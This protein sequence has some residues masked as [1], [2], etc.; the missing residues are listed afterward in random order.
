MIGSGEA[1]L[2]ETINYVLH[3][4]APEEQQI[5]ADNVYLTGGCSKF[6]GLLER[7]D[8]EL[9]EMRPFETTHRIY[10]AKNPALD[11]WYGARDFAA[12]PNLENYLITRSEYEE[13]GG[14][15]LKEYQLS[16]PYF[17]TPPPIVAENAG[18]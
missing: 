13:Y 14:E 11:A 15:Y 2:A 4:F 5:L 7:L 8:R 17:P 6:P 18:D 10:R 1:G 3:L 9:L 12:L 16:N